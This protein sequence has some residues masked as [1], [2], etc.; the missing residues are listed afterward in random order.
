MTKA[1]TVTLLF[2]GLG[3]SACNV[4]KSLPTSMT[5]SFVRS[6]PAFFGMGSTTA[7][8]ELTSTGIAARAAGTGMEVSASPLNGG[9][10]RH[11]E[12]VATSVLFKSVSCT[13]ESCRFVGQDCEGT[14]TK[15]AAGDVTIVS[16]AACASLS[17]KWLGPRSASQTPM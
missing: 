2:V 6:E 1:S 3:L 14:I 7:H 8:L 11:T 17:G 15:D 4:S 5:G 9:H 10:V 13:S 16:T 12:T